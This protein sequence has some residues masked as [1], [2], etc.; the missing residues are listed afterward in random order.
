MTDAPST[1]TSDVLVRA[2][3]L[4]RKLT[5]H[6]YRYYVLDDPEI[7]DAEY[8]RLFRELEALEAT[9][10]DLVTVD[11]PT[12][13]VG[14]E[15]LADF[16]EVE[17][18]VPMLSLKN[19][20]NA[21]EMRSFDDLVRREVGAAFIT[22]LAE[23]K[24]D[25]LAISVVYENGVLARAATRGDGRVGEDVTRQV[26]TI[27]SVPLRLMGQG[28]PQFLEI[29]GEVLLPLA[30]FNGLN[31]R[32]RN[33]GQGEFKNPRN[34]AA[35]SLR[36]LNPKITASR[37]LEMFCYGLG[38]AEGRPVGDTQHAAIEAL[39][40][41]GLR[42]SPYLRVLEGID[43]CIAYHSDIAA[44]RDALPFQIDGVVFKVDSLSYQRILGFRDRDPR[45]A[46]AFKFPPQ[47]ELTTV[48]SVAFQVGR[49]G[50]ITPVARLEPVQVGGVSVS[51]AT[52]HNMDEVRRKDVRSGDTVFVRRAGDVIPEVVR[53]LIERRP[54]DT[55]PVELPAH[56]PV[57][58]SDV[59]QAQGE[60]VARC[61]GGLFCAAQRKEAI[62]H[63]ASRRA[64]DIEGLGDKL[65]DQLVERDLVRDPSDL[66]RLGIDDYASLDRMAVKSAQNLR[67]ALD[68]SRETTFA[69]F[70]YALGIREVG[71][72][73]AAALAEHFGDIAPLMKAELSDFVRRGVQ[74]VGP[75]T[76]AAL[77]EYLSDHPDSETH[78]GLKNWLLGIGVRGINADIAAGIA[79]RFDS[80]G[81]LRAATPEALSGAQ[82]SVVEGVGPIVAAHIVA[83]FA[84]PHN[85]EV[86]ERLLDPE[87][88]GVHWPRLETVRRQ[89]PAPVLAGK[90]F[91]ITG[92]LSR[93]R[94]EIRAD[95]QAM[96]AK[97]SGSVSRNTDY[98]LAGADAGSKLKKAE[99]LGVPVLD[100]T[101]LARMIDGQ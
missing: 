58:G 9:Y 3:R 94:D 40:S 71:E 82:Q 30:A 19:A 100:E 10:P 63:F 99:S 78:C 24:F 57:C 15:P 56:C 59:V 33:S 12:Q 52:L 41:W 81:A 90:T 4:R 47:E 39:K 1:P 14:G 72:A 69:R 46:I 29:R 18:R 66:Y 16:A 84:Q 38:F 32:M 6:G 83:F 91:V 70:I 51:N 25:G 67:D 31:E 62:R 28:W 75:K 26:R 60:A 61:S 54:A 88:G 22:Y 43:D 73:T 17:H 2:E 92:A 65:I 64:M 13:R 101:Q 42:V 20:K 98:L 85:R 95:L 23:P 96:G 34:A 11:S 27:R 48:K 21:I 36:Q 74:G 86:I 77:I 97:V 76:A 37:P 7:P 55:H 89:M 35:G 93:P 80:I 53:V 5:H 49:T 45:W 8:D 87:L 44:K 68:Q 50:A 79:Q